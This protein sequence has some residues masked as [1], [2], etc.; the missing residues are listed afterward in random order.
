MTSQS[1]GGRS[2][3]PAMPR[4]N[5]VA[6][7][8][9]TSVLALTT[10][11]IISA[12]WP[13]VR[14]VRAVVV[15]QA[16]FEQ[17]SEQSS[18]DQPERVSSSPTVQAAGWLE[19]EP[20]ITAV[21]ALADGVVETVLVL[22]GDSV[23]R[24]AV[25]ATLVDDDAR[26]ARTR[27]EAELARARTGVDLAQ[28]EQHAAQTDWDHPVEL[29]RRV[30]VA[31]ADVAEAEGELARLPALIDSAEATLLRFDEERRRV[32]QA[33]SSRVATELEV[34][35]ARQGAEAQRAEVAALR[36][37]RPVLEARVASAIAEARAAAESLELRVADRLRLGS[38]NAAL[39]R[40]RADLDRAIAARDE[41]ALRLQRMTVRAP[42]SGYVQKRLKAPG[43]KAILMM[44]DPGSAQIIH[45]YDPSRLQVRVDV[46]LA[47]AA[48]VSVGQRCEVVVEVLP[49]TSF[50]GRVL[51]ITHEADLQKNTLE[52]KVAVENPSPLL[53]PEMLTR[54]RFIGSG[55]N[56]RTGD[57]EFQ[58]A[59]PVRVPARALDTSTAD[60]RLWLVTDRRASRGV[61][62]PVPV[63]VTRQDAD[64]ATVTGRIQPG[65]L[66]IEDPAGLAPGEPVAIRSEPS[67]EQGA[68]S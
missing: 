35:T 68:P 1:T 47:D 18:D 39:A 11:L 61:A 49:G 23:E 36:A 55:D 12:A 52:V 56:E 9:P 46:P 67:D 53:K 57:A 2:R 3:L 37:Q 16:V 48:H 20:Y 34:I 62:L 28:A 25:V 59:S 51:R 5:R 60:T 64:W 63:T 41:A 19:A 50:D 65:A 66:L 38:A 26:L 31:R 6:V 17:S 54:V 4:R 33:Q 15:T 44:D 13:T 45:I 24:G 8:V 32:E 21:P 27:A 22:E 29:Q 10:L 14:P 30:G 40:A 42:V 43:D 58:P 7:L